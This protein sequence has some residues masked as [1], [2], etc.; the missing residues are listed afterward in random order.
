MIQR[1]HHVKRLLELLRNH[2]VVALLGA[3]QVGK[4]TLANQ[5]LQVYPAPTHF[6]DLEKPSDLARLAEPELALSSLDGLIVI[7]EVQRQPDLFQII[8]VLADRR[9]LRA[10]FLILGSASPDL[11]RQGNETLAGRIAYHSLSGFSLSEVGDDRLDSLWLRGGFPRSFLATSDRLS[12][13]W[14]ENFTSTYLER[15]IPQFGIRVGA[16]TLRRFWTMLAHTHGQVWNASTFAKNFGVNHTTIRRYLDI[17]TSTLV[18]R[19]LQPWHANLKK[20][21]VKAP[22]VYFTDTGLLHSLLGIVNQRDLESHPIVGMSWESFAIHEI[23]SRLDVGPHE[24]YFWATHAGAEL[25]LLV[26]RGR[27]RWGFEIKRTSAPTIS[28]SMRIAATDL[29]LSQ[30]FIVH[31]GVDSFDLAENTRAIACTRLHNDLQAWHS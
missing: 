16:S 26:A 1:E 12:W 7:D 28:R 13:E 6:F 8:R 4:T 27:Q 3:R 2:P 25:D 24:C 17:L 9:P 23:V 29:S 22:K 15:D 30:L 11:L 18:V 5:L 14:R 20:R 19:T 21:Q 31:A 10:R